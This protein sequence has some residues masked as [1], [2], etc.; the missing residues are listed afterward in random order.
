MKLSALY[1][2]DDELFALILERRAAIWATIRE[3]TTSDKAADR[4]YEMM[5]DGIDEMKL[6]HKLKRYEKQM[7]ANRLMLEVLSGE[8][9]NL[10]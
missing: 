7:S 6:R 2:Q 10:M 3:K 9:R 8:A 1:A 4:Q 5:Q